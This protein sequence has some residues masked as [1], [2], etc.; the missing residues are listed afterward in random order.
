MKVSQNTQKVDINTY[1][2]DVD[3]HNKSIDHTVD[4]PIFSHS[5][6]PFKQVWMS[7][8]TNETSVLKPYQSQRSMLAEKRDFS[9]FELE[10]AYGAVC[11]L[12][13]KLHY[14]DRDLQPSESKAIV[15]TSTP[16]ASY[17]WGLA[18]SLPIMSALI[19][20]AVSYPPMS[21]SIPCLTEPC[22]S[23]QGKDLLPIQLSTLREKFAT[24][25]AV[26]LRPELPLAD[27]SL[28]VQDRQDMAD[29][30]K[31]GYSAAEVSQGAQTAQ[32]WQQVINLWQLALDSL[33]KIPPDSRLY[34]QAQSRVDLY[35]SNLDYAQAEF[36]EAP[37]RAG[38]RA[39][40]EASGLAVKATTQ[41]DWETVANEWEMALTMMQ[42]VSDKSQNYTVAQQKLVEYAKKFAYAQRQFLGDRLTS[43]H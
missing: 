38:V 15:L 31:F 16:K 43:P 30:L 27:D 40:E 18:C 8:Q 25:S 39:A 42:A 12:K 33:S 34:P 35:R 32:D 1:F 7:H 9:I 37:F 14:N 23:F 3:D 36:A 28:S 26:Q 17:R 4:R 20:V 6:M 13:E 24:V 21:Y 2:S 22:P 11:Q 29:S 5:V 41:A 10:T 19:A